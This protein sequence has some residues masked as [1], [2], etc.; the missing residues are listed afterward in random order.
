MNA[1]GPMTTQP[2]VPHGA[3]PRDE[4]KDQDGAQNA[5]SQ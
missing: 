3:G 4:V 1:A 2:S 5:G